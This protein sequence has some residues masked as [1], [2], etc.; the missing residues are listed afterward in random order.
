[1]KGRATDRAV[2]P[3]GP[4]APSP[5]ER[6]SSTDDG[7]HRPGRRVNWDTGRSVP[8]SAARGWREREAETLGP[9]LARGRS[10]RPTRGA[11]DCNVCGEDTCACAVHR[12]PE[13]YGREGVAEEELTML[14]GAGEPLEPQERQ[15]F[16]RRL[17]MD[18]GHVRLHRDARAA[19]LARRLGA[20]AFTYEEHLV[21]SA[22]ASQ[23]HRALAHQSR[24]LLAH[25]LIHIAQG[26]SPVVHRWER[27]ERTRPLMEFEVDHGRL[28]TTLDEIDD[29]FGSYAIAIDDLVFA[30]VAN[31]PRMPL[32]PPHPWRA[33]LDEAGVLRERMLQGT[34]WGSITRWLRALRNCLDVVNRELIQRDGDRYGYLQGVHVPLVESIV[35]AL[36]RVRIAARM[37]EHDRRE[38]RAWEARQEQRRAQAAEADRL[39]RLQELEDRVSRTPSGDPAGPHALFQMRGAA[40]LEGIDQ[41]S[42]ET[43]SNN[44][45]ELRR[46]ATSVRELANRAGVS[47]LDERRL[48]MRSAWAEVVPPLH[49][50]A[51]FGWDPVDALTW[52]DRGQRLLSTITSLLA[53]VAPRVIDDRERALDLEG[54]RTD[55]E[56]LANRWLS[57]REL[58]A[59]HETADEH[60][61][62][63]EDARAREELRE[64]IDVVRRAT[65][66]IPRAPS[67]VAVG[68][69]ERLTNM[70]LSV[71]DID[72]AYLQLR[73]E[74]PAAY[75][76]ALLG[77]AVFAHLRERGLEGAH[78]FGSQA[79][80]VES[81]PILA[82][83]GREDFEGAL[84]LFEA[85][86]VTEN[87][88]V[89]RDIVESLDESRFAEIG[90]V[91]AGRQLLRRFFTALV[92]GNVTAEEQAASQLIMLHLSDRDEEERE[93]EFRARRRRGQPAFVFP[94]EPQGL[95]APHIGAHVH[96]SMEGEFV[97][98]TMPV[99]VRG[100][101]RY[102]R[103]A[104]RLPVD[105]FNGRGLLIDSRETIAVWLHHEQRLEHHPAL[106]LL[107]LD[108][109]GRRRVAENVVEVA[110]TALTLG[111]GTGAT[112]S[113]QSASFLAR[114]AHRVGPVI[115]ALGFV[116]T[117]LRDHRAELIQSFGED[118]RDLADTLDLFL[119]GVLGVQAIRGL[120]RLS[121]LSRRMRDASATFRRNHP[122]LDAR[123][124]R[125]L[126]RMERAARAME[127]HVGALDPGQARSL[128]LPRTQ[129]SLDTERAL[130]ELE[131]VEAGWAAARR[132]AGDVDPPAPRA[133]AERPDAAGGQSTDARAARRDLTIAR[134]GVEAA[135]RRA[136]GASAV[137]AAD[138]AGPVDDVARS[139]DAVDD[140]RTTSRA[141]DAETPRPSG[142][143]TELDLAGLTREG[144]R[145]AARFS[146]DVDLGRGHALHFIGDVLALCSDCGSLH[147][148]LRLLAR[149]LPDDSALRRALHRLADDALAHHRRLADQPAAARRALDRQWAEQVR[150]RLERLGRRHDELHDLVDE[151]I[152]ALN[153]RAEHEALARGG[154]DEEIRGARRVRGIAAFEDAVRRGG[155][156][157]TAEA[158]AAF[159]QRYEEGLVLQDGHWTSLDPGRRSPRFPVGTTP[160]AALRVLRESPEF[161]EYAALL[162]RLD[163]ADEAAW[164]RALRT[165]PELDGRT[166]DYVRHRVKAEFRGQLL[167]HLAGFPRPAQATQRRTLLEAMG[168]AG[169]PPEAI[170]AALHR[171]FLDLTDDLGPSDRGNL[172]EAFNR[173]V[174]LASEGHPVVSHVR[175]DQQALRELG[176]PVGSDRVPDHLQ[177]LGVEPDAGVARVRL[178]D[179][180][181]YTGALTDHAMS[182][183]RDFAEIRAARL[184]EPIPVS[185]SL[186]DGTALT[187]IHVEE[188]VITFTRPE[189]LGIRENSSFVREMLR[190]DVTFRVHDS[191]G[192]LQPIRTQ[193]DLDRMLATL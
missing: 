67:V 32:Y 99:R 129:R 2:R 81:R 119:L 140:G 28:Y 132:A 153:R 186:P 30:I 7:Q 25:E 151:D 65:R 145:R 107:D 171:R 90:A 92:N 79:S 154:G 142:G 104:Q 127:V 37:E 73:R 189:V 19:G 148:R 42:R 62:L 102:A 150:Q 158:R 29:R 22:P 36:G 178:L 147:D 12:S 46:L 78:G 156:P 95:F 72:I 82:A 190:R 97:R 183:I 76:R 59:I 5:T 18:L 172:F 80:E 70:G 14:R 175:L 100:N 8:V 4:R 71:E 166:L 180:K 33:A 69:V 105:V 125:L 135:A 118:G 60:R 56:W 149:F 47:P 138:Q 74:D 49:R 152:A 111:I 9:H 41:A 108:A 98:V 77:G 141:A 6:S 159:V 61:A 121:G 58:E 15:F 161:Q 43:L 157:D 188:V 106:F 75:H 57:M 113:L 44:D 51:V 13:G 133:A 176:V 185:V 139:A 110:L 38:R 52:I 187:G 169:E 88:D 27:E 86:G 84:R 192:R 101:P 123:R 54:I 17:G 20:R 50:M 55:Q 94:F 64:A 109:Q 66:H 163:I 117:F 85:L 45:S 179:D 83:I 126:R 174:H 91:S 16:E 120:S 93:S 134:E 167:D 53:V 160:E 146:L 168:I 24:E 1:M 96:A 164:L 63:V 21:L 177:V 23:E 122:R 114:M 155:Q 48:A 137:R 193:R 181:N 87:D 182:Q 89:A 39:R 184:Q 31:T 68:L 136:E 128:D 144:A 115:E 40:Y 162:R 116:S 112:A 103:L 35:A 165:F 26:P 170:R 131:E 130:A 34:S 11:T 3:S 173:R 143:E 10:V 124:T 191:N